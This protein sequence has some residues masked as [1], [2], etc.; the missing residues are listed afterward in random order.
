MAGE[1]IELALEARRMAHVVRVHTGDESAPRHL[2]P[3]VQCARHADV[4]LIL[5]KNDPGVGMAAHDFLTAVRGAVV[6]D[7][8]FEIGPD[9]AEN[10]LKC[11]SQED[12]AIVNRQKDANLR[13]A[14]PRP[15]SLP[16]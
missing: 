15:R 13:H 10:A 3:L 8:A 2:H 12:G 9:L 5:H 16:S 1:A 14:P 11:L 7:D 4:F 6:Q